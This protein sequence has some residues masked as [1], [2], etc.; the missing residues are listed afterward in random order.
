VRAAPG[1]AEL[2]YTAGRAGLWQLA[3]AA[4][5]DLSAERDFARSMRGGGE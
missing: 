2:V 3:G 4:S 5:R 1:D